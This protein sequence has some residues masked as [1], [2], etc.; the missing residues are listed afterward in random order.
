MMSIQH[1]V[2]TGVFV[3]FSFFAQYTFLHF[4]F[5]PLAYLIVSNGITFQL[6]SSFQ[7][8]LAMVYDRKPGFGIRN[9]NQGPILVSVLEAKLFCHVYTYYFFSFFS[10]TNS[11]AFLLLGG[12]SSFGKFFFLFGSKIYFQALFQ[13]EENFLSYW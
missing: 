8:Y 6:P 7:S 11:H 1:S 9:Q 13:D 12:D 2:F 3:I 5:F 10:K 4:R